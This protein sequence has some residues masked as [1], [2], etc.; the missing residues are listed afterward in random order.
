[1]RRKSLSRLTFTFAY[2][3]LAGGLTPGWARSSQRAYVAFVGRRTGSP[4][5]GIYAYRL[6]PAG[7]HMEF[8]VRAAKMPAPSFIAVHPRQKFLFAVNGPAGNDR[9]S[10]NTVTAFRDR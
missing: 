3:L 5:P 2:L 9:A 10:G 1:M 4:S 8:L 6:H 7:A